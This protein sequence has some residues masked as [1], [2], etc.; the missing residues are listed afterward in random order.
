MAT[1][2]PA[3]RFPENYM[4]MTRD[5]WMSIQGERRPGV[6]GVLAA[7]ASSALMAAALH[8]PAVPSAVGPGDMGDHSSPQ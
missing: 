1:T 7:L 3:S 8:H 5:D 6:G 4:I 2:G